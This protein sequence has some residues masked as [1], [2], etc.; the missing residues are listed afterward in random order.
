MTFCTEYFM[1]DLLEIR[2]HFTVLF[3]FWLFMLQ[4]LPRETA[5]ATVFDFKNTVFIHLQSVINQRA[6]GCTK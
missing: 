3:L 1:I 4:W 5:D 6:L 2:F